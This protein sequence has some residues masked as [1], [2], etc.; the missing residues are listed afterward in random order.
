MKSERM[1][2][3]CTRGIQALLLAV[4]VYSPLAFG[5]TGAGQ[6]AVVE[7]LMAGVLLLWAGKLSSTHSTRI[8]WPPVAW[9][10][11]LVLA[12]AIARYAVADVEYLARQELL[13]LVV[14][15][16]FF[17]ALINH[18]PRPD[19]GRTWLLV[20]Y[21][22]AALIASYAVIQFL[23]GANRVWGVERPAIYAHR[24][25]GT[26][27]SPNHLAGFLEMLLPAG[28]IFAL[29]DRLPRW[30]RWLVGLA[31]LTVVAG[32]AVT[33][34]RGGWLAAGFS[35]LL[36]FGWILLNK[37][38]RL[39]AS[40]WAI[41]LTS[42]VV[43]LFFCGHWSGNRR[44][45][46][47]DANQFVDI[48]FNIWLKAIDMWHD[49]LW[50]G[51]GPNH[52]DTRFP[53][54][55]PVDNTLQ[56]H[57]QRVHNDYLNVLVDWGL[58]G[59]GLL[60]LALLVWVWRAWKD[61]PVVR[62]SWLERN[63][64]GVDLAPTTLAALF[65]LSAIWAH[66]LVDFNLHVPANALVAVSLAA[67]VAAQ[68][69]HLHSGYEVVVKPRL[70]WVMM[71][72]FVVASG[73][74][75]IQATRLSLESFWLD[76]AAVWP[77]YAFKQVQLFKK[78]HAIQPAR[79][80]TV[81]DIG[82][83]YRLRSWQGEGDYQQ[84]ATEALPWFQEA[85]RLNPW[86]P[87]SRLRYGMCLDWLGKHEEAERFYLEASKLDWNGYYTMAYLGWHYMQVGDVDGARK[88]FSRSR[89]L[90]WEDNPIA[91]RYLGLLY[92]ERHESQSTAE[93][94]EGVDS[95]SH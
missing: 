52:F 73:L 55:R 79:A 84:M 7:W 18:L 32:L 50:L 56:G 88:W 68:G 51:V 26:Y 40:V 64:P 75:A 94:V 90:N 14:Y 80:Q 16:I 6:F 4:V 31:T 33:G 69:R 53:Q 9:V 45:A 13:R 25:S 15:S 30:G 3:W 41:G 22:I 48:R 59:F 58:M 43:V 77:R 83:C 49:H 11:L 86:D 37:L 91:S 39:K 17:V 63:P 62:K 67:L 5:A 78:A 57:P 2:A 82:E 81:Y 10:I 19:S 47:R 36:F 34:S 29:G 35:L 61:W 76:R 95:S 65:G 70:R 42:L 28:L 89:N 23:S 60:G 74:I 38:F 54:Y 24:G 21:A 8:F 44:G 92:Q 85:M 46:F 12:Y 72:G 27:I 20:V 71:G 93:G 66:S 87:L 1:E